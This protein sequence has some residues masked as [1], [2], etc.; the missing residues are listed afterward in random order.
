MSI[1]VEQILLKDIMRSSKILAGSRGLSKEIKKISFIDGPIDVKD[2]DTQILSRN[3]FY[4]SSLYFTKN[5]TA[6][7]KFLVQTLMETES[8]GLGIFDHFIKEIP[9]EVEEMANR[10]G[11]PIIMINSDIPYNEIIVALTEEVLAEQQHTVNNIIIDSILHSNNTY[12]EKRMI[13]LINKSFKENI[14]TVYFSGN[15]KYSKSYYKLALRISM[16]KEF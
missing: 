15:R 8:S 5:D 13:N 3:S 11:Y 1:T 9:V 16:K 2:K 12:S 10:N 6:Y 7:L 4:I 14:V